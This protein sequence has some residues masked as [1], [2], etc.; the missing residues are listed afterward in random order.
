M[1][2]TMQMQIIERPLCPVH[3]VPMLV[4]RTKGKIRYC[5]CPIADCKQSCKVVRII[6]KKIETTFPDAGKAQFQS[7]DTTP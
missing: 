7:P 6:P 3:S 2:H 4:G 5:Y 1:T